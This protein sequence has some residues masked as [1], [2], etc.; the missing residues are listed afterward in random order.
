M[1][2]FFFIFIYL[3]I[4]LLSGCKF[5]SEMNLRQFGFTKDACGPPT[6]I[7]K[8][9]EEHKNLNKYEFKYI[10]INTN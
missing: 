5:M 8:P 6:H 2:F 10:F 9:K 3:F 1:I 4:F 7:L